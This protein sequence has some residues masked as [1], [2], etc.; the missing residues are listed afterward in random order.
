MSE[1]Q[2]GKDIKEL[3]NRVAELGEAIKIIASHSAPCSKTQVVVELSK[4]LSSTDP[5]AISFDVNERG[6]CTWDKGH[7][8][9]FFGNGRVIFS[10]TVDCNE[11]KALTCT[12]DTVIYA[13]LDSRDGPLIEVMNF[14]N[15][16]EGVTR[17]ASISRE[18][19]SGAVRDSFDRIWGASISYSCTCINC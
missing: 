19:S 4:D 18:I 5:K 9:A 10:C 3:E 15:E 16:Y 13:V 17:D 12:F 14:R 8:V 11:P 6:R 2:I 1:Y 7:S